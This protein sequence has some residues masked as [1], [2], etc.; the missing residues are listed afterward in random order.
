M[1]SMADVMR[2]GVA[3]R[4]TFA[5]APLEARLGAPLGAVLVALSR[6][7]HR[8]DPRAPWLA[9]ASLEME[10]T[11]LREDHAAPIDAP[12]G[13]I[14]F[15]E[16]AVDTSY[17]AFAADD[18]NTPLS[19]RPILFVHESESRV[20][21][22]DLAAFLGRAAYAGAA[23]FAFEATDQDWRDAHEERT[24]DK[25]LIRTLLGLPGVSLFKPCRQTVKRVAASARRIASEPA[26]T[27]L[28]RVHQ[29]LR[30]GRA[31]AAQ[32]EL[33]RQI[34]LCTGIADLMPRERWSEIQELIDVVRP[35]L[36]RRAA[37]ALLRCGVRCHPP[38]PR[39]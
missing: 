33:R 23:M 14:P 36:S 24:Q 25:K 12:I 10:L 29:L 16:T 38:L 18:G 7:A 3:P 31:S 9:F 17:A 4:R 1:T 15:V 35:G 11:Y 39:G 34:D 13:S 20:V 37:E 30:Q 21:A 8:L 26:E 2:D 5:A 28:G 6:L 19:S 22:P 27:G 32:T